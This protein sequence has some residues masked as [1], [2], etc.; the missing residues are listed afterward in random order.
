MWIIVWFLIFVVCFLVLLLLLAKRGIACVLC[1]LLKPHKPEFGSERAPPGPGSVRIP[2]DIY[3]R[4]DPLIYSQAY[5]M[6]QG[7]AVTWD[8]PDIQLQTVGLDGRP[9]GTVIPSHLLL[10]N[11]V[12]FVVARIWNG[13]VDGP[14][15]DLPVHFSYLTFGI[16]TV[17]QDIGVMKVDLPVKGTAGCPAF[18]AMKWRTP[19]VA[20]HYCLQVR[21]E[22]PD[23]E[24]ENPFNNLGQEN[25]TVKPLNSPHAAF[26][27]PVRNE[28]GIRRILTLET[29]FYELGPRPR[30]REKQNPAREP[31]LSP[32]EVIQ[33]RR[34]A[35]LEH[36]R[37]AFPVAPGWIIKLNPTEIALAPGEE[38]FVTVDVTAPDS[39]KGKQAIN[40]NAFA[41]DQLAGG[42]TLYVT[43]GNT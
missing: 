12:Y 6:S 18:A 16:A 1:D 32:D 14:A 5:L 19:P 35:Q 22:W 25:V 34:A 30:C 29:D 38:T 13:S 36:R 15:V 4:P 37:G 26:T 24:D 8:N 27:F 43:G 41:D 9:S 39:F 40:V 33:L 10:P 2:K 11:T 3:K 7:L 20:G 23:K 31:R 28:I 17:S 21:L 42:V